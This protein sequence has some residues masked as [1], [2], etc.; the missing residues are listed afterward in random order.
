MA[1]TTT[2]RHVAIATKLIV[3]TA[4]SNTVQ[5]DVLGTTGTL[6]TLFVNNGN[7]HN[8]YIKLFNKIVV[9]LASDVADLVYLVPASTVDCL[10]IDQGYAFDVGLS[11]V[12]VRNPTDTDDTAPSAGVAVRLVCS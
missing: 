9:S 11:M 2:D 12:C 4:L 10:I 8:V 7:A 3:D 1:T 5:T 6:Y